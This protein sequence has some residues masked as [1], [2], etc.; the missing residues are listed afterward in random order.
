MRY[1]AQAAAMETSDEPRERLRFR[2]SRESPHSHR[3][4]ETY[5]FLN[6]EQPFERIEQTVRNAVAGF[7]TQRF[8]RRVQQLVDQ[9]LERL[10]NLLCGPCR[11]TRAAC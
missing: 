8:Q 6:P 1:D 4:R 11:P 5:L 9:S 3:T 10:R 7:V 2:V